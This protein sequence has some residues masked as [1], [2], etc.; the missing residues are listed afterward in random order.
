MLQTIF[1]VAYVW[2][3]LIYGDKMYVPQWL[4]WSQN[5]LN[6]YFSNTN[7]FPILVALNYQEYCDF[8]HGKSVAAIKAGLRVSS[9][10]NAENRKLVNGILYY[11][12]I[13]L[14]LLFTLFNAVNW[15][16]NFVADWILIKG[17]HMTAKQANT[18]NIFFSIFV[19][20]FVVKYVATPAKE[21]YGKFMES[22][23]NTDSAPIEFAAPRE[24]ASFDK[25]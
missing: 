10:N 24:H 16:P 19:I 1:F 18:Y 13:D 4:P 6:V 14:F 12:S 23:N 15:L 20:Y 25:L 7:I 9:V 22:R 2:V 21:W 17:F 11:Q 8:M 5:A 3:G